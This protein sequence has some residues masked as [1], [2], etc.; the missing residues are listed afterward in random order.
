MFKEMQHY[1]TLINSAHVTRQ[2][3]TIEEYHS[4]VCSFQ[5]RLLQ[6]QGSLSDGLSECLRLAMLAFLITT[7]QFPGTRAQYPYLANCLKRACCEVM[8]N[9]RACHTTDIMGW[10]IIVGAIW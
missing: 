10:V 8:R 1:S 5:Y 2:R 4:V 3:R 6:L 7:F 9:D